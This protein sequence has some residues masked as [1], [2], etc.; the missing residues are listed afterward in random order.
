MRDDGWMRRASVAAAIA[1]SLVGCDEN[2]TG[3]DGNPDPYGRTG[4]IQISI[5][6]DASGRSPLACRA[7]TACAG[8][9]AFCPG[10]TAGDVTAGVEWSS[11]N[12]NVVRIVGRGAFA[13]VAPGD[14]VVGVTS[15]MVA[16]QYLVGAQRTVSVFADLAVFPTRD[17]S[18]S[19]YEAG[20]L[21]SQGAIPGAVVEILDGRLARSRATTGAPAPP[22]PGFFPFGCT[23]AGQYC[24]HAVPPGTYHLRVSAAGFVSEE[25]EVVLTAIG[26]RIVDFALRRE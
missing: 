5:D 6:C 21:A 25:R 20:T 22:P 13:A 17:I 12:Q 11:E 14:T 2:V 19:V 10:F 8:L 9:Y 1:L 26:S 16:G 3:P 18:G 23:S 15:Q 4:Y 7:T 24:F